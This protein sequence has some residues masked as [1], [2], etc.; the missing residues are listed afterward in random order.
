MTHKHRITAF[1]LASLLFLSVISTGCAEQTDLPPADESATDS[2]SESVS[3]TEVTS[4]PDTS[5][6]EKDEPAVP[7][8]D[9][10]SELQY[11]YIHDPKYENVEKYAKGKRELSRPDGIL[12]DFSADGLPEAASYT[13]QYSDNA[14]FT[15]AVTVEGLTE[16]NYRVLN[17]KLGQKLFWRAGTDAANAEDGTVHELTVAEQGPRNLFIDGVSNVRDI[18]GYASSLVEGGKIRQGLYYRGAKPDDI[19]EAGMAEMLRLGIRREIDLRDADQCNGP[20]VDGVAYT[21]VS[22]PSGTEPTRFE[23]F[24]A[25]YRQIFALIANADAAPVYLHCTAGADRTGICTFMLL[26]VCGAEYDDIAR[27]YLFTN[28]STQGSRVSNY[29]SEFKQWWKKLDAF[30][31]DTKADKAKSWLVSKGVPAEQVETIREIFVEG[32]TAS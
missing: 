19:T 23:A 2:E 13:V 18:G 15:D 27:D 14:S 8:D 21:A 26:T 3:D 31:G 10:H 1:L 25:E 30:E 7:A 12:L 32:Y 17:L 29:T 24:D 5:A 16:Q 20:Y 4:A 9:F 11:N 6:P 22:I 28:F